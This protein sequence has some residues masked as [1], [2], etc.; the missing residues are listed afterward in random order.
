MGRTAGHLLRVRRWW[1]LA[2]TDTM[3]GVAYFHM[4]TVGVDDGPIKLRQMTTWIDKGGLQGPV[5]VDTGGEGSEFWAGTEE[6]RLG[7]FGQGCTILATDGSVG[8]KDMGAGYVLR[9]HGSVTD[10][11]GPSSPVGTNDGNDPNSGSPME[12]VSSK[13]AVTSL[14]AIQL[15]VR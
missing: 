7:V 2:S 9:Q 3:K 15:H 4:W 5:S 11:N 14:M 10:W 12:W 1:E 13:I 6:G 8:E